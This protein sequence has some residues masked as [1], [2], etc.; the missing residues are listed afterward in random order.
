MRNLL[1]TLTGIICAALL[2]FIIEMLSTTL[3]P[4]PDGAKPMDRT[5]LSEHMH[6]IP[7]GAMIMVAIAHTLG[8]IIGMYVA[9]IIAK[10]SL[11]PT[12]IVAGFMGLTTLSNLF[13]IP[14][15]NWFVATDIIG[16]LIGI[17]FGLKLA[18]SKSNPQT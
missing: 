4:L 8:L 18:K 15:P 13:M 3:F 5:W 7:L 2:T 11:N 16:V 17:M 1:A 6:L 12:Y 9:A 14:H 10:S